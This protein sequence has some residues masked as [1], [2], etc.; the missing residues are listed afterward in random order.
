LRFSIV[1]FL[2]HTRT[3]VPNNVLDKF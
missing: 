1:L 2:L 3:L